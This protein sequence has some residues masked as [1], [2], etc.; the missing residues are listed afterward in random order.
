MF[1]KLPTC[2][3]LVF[4]AAMT[5]FHSAHAAEDPATPA[6]AQVPSSTPGYAQQIQPIFNRRCIACHGC[7]GSPCNIKLDSF[8]GVDRGG[9]GKNPYSVHVEPYPRTDMD[10]AQT[11]EQWRGR[12]FYPILARGGST[13]ENLDQSLMYQMLAAGYRHNKPGF[14][15]EA[16]IPLYRKRFDHRCP[17]TPAALR[18]QLDENSAQGMP[19]GLPAIGEEDFNALRSWIAAGSPGPTEE[20][21]H[22]AAKPANPEA[23]RQWEEFF[24]GPDKR[25]QLVSRYIFEHVFL[26]GILLEESPGDIFRLVRSK[27]PPTSVIKGKDG[28][29]RS[30]TPPVEIIA[31][32]LPYDD[33]YAYAGVDRFYYRLQKIT[34][35]IV[36]KSHFVWRLALDDIEHLKQLF[37]SSDWDERA[38][39]DP[40]WGIGNPFSVFRAIPAEAR[41]RFLLEN[42]ELIVSGITY[43]P[44]CLG[45]TAT[46]AVKDHFW[47]YFIDPKYD[48]SVQDPDL[49]L[50]TWDV[51][52]NRSVFGNAEYEAAYADALTKLNPEGYP[53]DAIWNG[54][55]INSNAWLTIMR[56]ETNVSVLKGRQG[57]LPRTH[58]LMD[59]SGL[60]RMYYDTVA[61]FKYWDGNIGKLQTLLFFNYLRQEFEDNFLLLLPEDERGK[62]RHEWTQ[63]IGSIELILVPFA[64]ED[65]PTQIETDEPHPLLGLVG[66]IENHMGPAVT[67]PADRLNPRVK[68]DVSLKAPI[69][70]AGDWEQAISTLTA[71]SDHGFPH[72]LPSVILLKLNCAGESRVYSLVANRVYKSQYTLVFENGEALPEENTMSVYPTLIGGFPNLFIELDTKQAPQFLTDLRGID[73]L[74]DW[75]RF[76]SRYAILRNSERL[77]PFYD[78][79][80]EWNFRNRGMDAGYPDLSYYDS[81]E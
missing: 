23:V 79:I 24:N 7:L 78:W 6:Q 14:S 28:E 20:E 70:N 40:P 80:T 21:L 52:M 30:V 34:T 46:Y 66:E 19:F 42:A 9:L 62:I 74:E 81:P 25:L 35:P 26:A 11:T 65:Q 68:P 49:G 72:F 10:V 4:L 45:Q 57:G 37:L 48:V 3:P 43:G 41:Y 75:T 54:D 76:K 29:E 36:Q 53:I 50:A 16:L 44:V 61:S 15:R 38:Q 73:T 12:G 47:V 69:E 63:G 39:L 2:L 33:P 13:E 17:S 64:G 27:T 8:R 1:P 58:W 31:T 56:H 18:A 77:W 51:F 22:G 60:E 5:A 67:G 59:Y 32:P 71:T 55:G